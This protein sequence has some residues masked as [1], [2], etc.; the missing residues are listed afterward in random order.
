MTDALATYVHLCEASPNGNPRTLLLLHGTGDDERHFLELG[1][2][3][4]P[5]AALLSLRGNVS[6]HGLNRF[7]RRR[8]EGVYDMD[9]LARRTAELAAFLKAAIAHYRIA[10]DGLIGVGYSN[11]ANILAN[12]LFHEP[13]LV[14]AAVL[15]HP[16][17][18]FEPPANPALAG[19]PVLITAGERDPICPPQLS[20]AL[21][22]YLERQGAASRLLFQP[23][24]HEISSLEL[25]AAR[26]FLA[27]LASPDAVAD[28]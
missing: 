6:E 5:D 14:S 23:G 25:G 22:A 4:A 16:L 27:Q 18:P 1:R 24:G 3:L 2:T 9:D 12:L 8:G 20:R 13:A 28:S 15:L 7:F 11:G 21:H 26:A 19:K 17:I 10:A